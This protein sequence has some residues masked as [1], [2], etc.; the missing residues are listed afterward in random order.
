MLHTIIL[1]LPI[2]VL[3]V[4]CFLGLGLSL[5]LGAD[6]DK[7]KQKL[8]QELQLDYKQYVAKV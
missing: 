7:K 5:L 2:H 8:Q 4:K 3:H 6:Y 1:T